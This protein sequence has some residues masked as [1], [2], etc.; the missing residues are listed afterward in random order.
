MIVY[1]AQQAD[2][3]ILREVGPELDLFEDAV[4]F[5]CQ[6]FTY[7]RKIARAQFHQ[8]L[9]DEPAF[10]VV[11]TWFRERR[12][13]A[14]GT[15]VGT[16][17]FMGVLFLV[18][19]YLQDAL[20]L[21]AL[22]AGISQAI[23]QSACDTVFHAIGVARDN[24]GQEWTFVFGLQANLSERCS[25]DAGML[26]PLADSTTPFARSGR[27]GGPSAAWMR[28]RDPVWVTRLRI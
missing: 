2:G 27:M 6:S 20:E 21:S 18:P 8:R 17:G 9:L 3:C 22:T 13:L 26:V 16:A 5:S 12:G 1:H 11:A 25:L 15:V 10:A 24:G 4:Q 7:K 28:E 19:L 23:S 14:I